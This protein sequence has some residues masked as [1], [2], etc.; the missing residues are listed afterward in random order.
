MKTASKLFLAFILPLSV[1][2]LEFGAPFSDRMVLQC[3]KPIPVWG[4]AEPGTGLTIT[5]GVNVRKC[6]ADAQGKWNI[7]FPAREASFEPIMLKVGNGESRRVCVDVLVGEVWY[8]S[9]QSNMGRRL[10]A[11]ADAE[12]Y[13]AQANLP[14]V[15]YAEVPL[16]AKDEPQDDVETAWQVWTPDSVMR[17]SGTAFHFGKKLAEEIDKPIGIISCSWG[18]S[19][20]QAWIPREYFS[21]DPAYE[22]GNKRLKETD[23]RYTEA[24]KHWKE[25]GI[26][27]RG[28]CI[29]FLYLQG[30][31]CRRYTCL[32]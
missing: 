6:I 20:I 25:N 16:T 32:T 26:L 29:S 12:T 13:A 11:T 18:G 9:G 15:R 30:R 23:S 28:I 8:C 10:N 27:A 4:K 1:Q 2:A 31:R 24:L 5:L 19:K 7:S 17:L 21:K 14:H 3:D 22:A